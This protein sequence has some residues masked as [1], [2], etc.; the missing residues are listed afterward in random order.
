LTPTSWAFGTPDIPC[1]N[2]SPW[3]IRRLLC[4]TELGS[5]QCMAGTHR[6]SRACR[7]PP[8]NASS[9][10]HFLKVIP[11]IRSIWRVLGPSCPQERSESS[12]P[13]ES[14]SSQAPSPAWVGSSRKQLPQYP[15]SSVYPVFQLKPALYTTVNTWVEG[16]GHKGLNSDICLH[17]WVWTTNCSLPGLEPSY[18][19]R[20]LVA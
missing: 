11:A 19:L 5:S 9:S 17:R 3:N 1:R 10:I 4:L 8:R 18:A 13:T 20:R 6:C 16:R 12:V 14:S 2:I 15:A 7:Q